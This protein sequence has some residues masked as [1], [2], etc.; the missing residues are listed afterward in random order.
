MSFAAARQ[1]IAAKGYARFA[2]DVQVAAWATHAVRLVPAALADPAYAHWHRHQGTW[3]A[4]VDALPNDGRGALPGGPALAGGVISFVRQQLGFEGSWHRAQL[5][6]CFPGY[7]KQDE[8]E[9]ASAHAFRRNRDAAHVDGLHGEGPAKRRHLREFHHFI[10]G[11][12]LTEVGEGAAPFTVWEGSHHIMAAMFR[13]AL[14]GLPPER[15]GDADLTEAYQ[16]ARKRAFETCPRIVLQARPGEAYAV[17]RHALHG[18][19]P[20]RDGA[21]APPEGRAIAYFR[22]EMQKRS[23]W[24]SGD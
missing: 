15:W 17:H 24:L 1:D 19:A 23:D 5:S 22:P 16:A 18:V 7:P 14:A 11:L 13:T 3:F 8:D 6:V 2:S 9:S 10:L 20:W 12:P 4:G 21:V